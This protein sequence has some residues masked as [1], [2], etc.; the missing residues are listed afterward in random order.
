[1]RD[2]AFEAFL[3]E[4]VI[5][6]LA[7]LRASLGW[8]REVAGDRDSGPQDDARRRAG[9]ERI[10]RQIAMLD[11]RARA[12]CRRIQR[13]DDDSGR[14]DATEPSAAA[15][16]TAPDRD[17]VVAVAAA[18]PLA[19][20]G[21]DDRDDGLT[22]RLAPSDNPAPAAPTIAEAI[23]DALAGGTPDETRAASLAGAMTK[24]AT[25]PASVPAAKD[26]SADA[27]PTEV[28]DTTADRI[29]TW[30]A[31]EVA[32]AASTVGL[33]RTGAAT[34]PIFRSRRAG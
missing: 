14:A 27:G 21:A 8:F 4:D 16:A 25:D 20:D 23:R 15:A 30:T 3:V 11:D 13:A 7:N 29:A 12:L 19:R 31:D 26:A 6:T 24:A 9:L 5:L 10:E 18:A 17:A 34:G 28:A 32:E 33:A 22:A 2:A 1:M